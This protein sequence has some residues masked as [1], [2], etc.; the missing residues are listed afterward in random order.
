MTK[1]TTPAHFERFNSE[2]QML[3]FFGKYLPKL[4]VLLSARMVPGVYIYDGKL[5]T[6]RHLWQFLEEMEEL[7]GLGIDV[8][9]STVRLSS[10]ILFF[11]KPLKDAVKFV[12]DS[13][14]VITSSLLTTQLPEQTPPAVD[15]EGPPTTDVAAILAEAEALRND[16]AK[17]AA[18]QALE[19]FGLKHG[20]SLTKSKTFDNMLEELKE[21]LSK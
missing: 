7:T 1:A 17:A 8:K 16:S 11:N 19:E 10:Y 15:P 6:T 18:K 2:Y 3:R 14:P 5:H 4:D 9:S 12:E 20:A 13:A 21:H